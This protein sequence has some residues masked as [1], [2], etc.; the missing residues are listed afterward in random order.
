MPHAVSV[1]ISRADPRLKYPTQLLK[2]EPVAAAAAAAANI[3]LD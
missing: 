1:K 3:S 2:A